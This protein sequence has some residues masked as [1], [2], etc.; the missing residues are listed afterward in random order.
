MTMLVVPSHS[1]RIGEARDV[2]RAR[3]VYRSQRT[4]R[5]GIRHAAGSLLKDLAMLAVFLLVA[6]G[7]IALRAWLH[8]PQI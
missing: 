2:R 8:V 1:P 6:A 7:V 4:S 5:A 3:A